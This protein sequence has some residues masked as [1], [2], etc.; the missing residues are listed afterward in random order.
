[1]PDKARGWGKGTLGI[2]GA[3]ID[4][5]IRLF[6]IS[7]PVYSCIFNINIFGRFC[8]MSVRVLVRGKQFRCHWKHLNR[9]LKHSYVFFPVYLFQ[10]CDKTIMISADYYCNIHPQNGSSSTWFLVELEVVND[11]CFNERGKT[12]VPGEKTSRTKGENREHYHCDDHIFISN[13][14]FCR[15]HSLPAR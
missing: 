4:S 6:H 7:L 8:N 14:Y 2:A 5:S 11:W 10:D 12:G 3:I 1:M 15:S 9:I 13:L